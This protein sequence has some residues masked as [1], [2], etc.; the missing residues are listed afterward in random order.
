MKPIVSAVHAWFWWVTSLP[1]ACWIVRMSLAF[2][3]A[4]VY[5]VVV[6]IF[7]IVILSVLGLLFR[8]NHPELVGGDEDPEDG[9]AVAATVFTAVIIYVVRCVSPTSWRLSYG[10]PSE[11][12]EHL[13]DVGCFQGFLVFCGFQGL[14][15]L[16]ENR[17]GTIAL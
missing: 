10:G 9:P 13:A 12:C 1:S 6:S 3:D 15:H 2:A 14:L 16:R 7:A 11:I 4:L 17:R 8:A 5:S